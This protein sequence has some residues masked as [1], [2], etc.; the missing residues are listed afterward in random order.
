MLSQDK[1]LQNQSVPTVNASMFTSFLHFCFF[2]LNMLNVILINVLRSETEIK[3]TQTS[4]FL[5]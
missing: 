5:Y 1:T 4:R 2:G 3:L